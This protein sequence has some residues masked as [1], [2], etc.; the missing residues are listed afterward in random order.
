MSQNCSPCHLGTS[1]LRFQK[2]PDL[3][4]VCTRFRWVCGGF[5][6]HPRS[7]CVWILLWMMI[8]HYLNDEWGYLNQVGNPHCYRGM[9]FT[10]SLKVEY[11]SYFWHSFLGIPVWC[12]A[13]KERQCTMSAVS[14]F[15]SICKCSLNFLIA[16]Y[17]TLFKNICCPI[18]MLSHIS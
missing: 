16:R 7:P 13:L 10:S 4:M 9:V 15:P 6:S 3:R 8:I 18:S 2:S 11:C 17:H 1:G 14:H 12:I 5:L